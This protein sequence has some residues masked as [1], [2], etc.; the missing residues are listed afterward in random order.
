MRKAICRVSF[1][2]AALLLS[3]GMRVDT[4]SKQ[5]AAS[6][7]RSRQATTIEVKDFS[8][9]PAALTVRA[10]TR[11]TWVNRDEEPHTIVSTDKIFASN[12]LDT[13]DQFSFTFSKPGRYE[14]FCTIHPRMV[15]TIIVKDGDANSWGHR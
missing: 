1:V 9:H 15:G 2:A 14:Y 4:K 12:A 3:L 6:P 5:A 11:V 8:F 7:N 13:T 10:G